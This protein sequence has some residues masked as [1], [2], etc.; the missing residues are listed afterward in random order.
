MFGLFCVKLHHPLPSFV[1]KFMLCGVHGLVC[2]CVCAY[3]SVCVGVH[4]LF[5]LTFT[6]R[7]FSRGIL[8]KAVHLSKERQTTIYACIYLCTVRMFI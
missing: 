7:A 8:F 1:I 3:V 5:T 2:A 6:F 4:E